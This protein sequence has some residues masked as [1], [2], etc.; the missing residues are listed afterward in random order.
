METFEDG[1]EV[2]ARLV[3]DGGVGMVDVTREGVLLPFFNVR[4]GQRWLGTI[5]CAVF[6]IA[7]GGLHGNYSLFKEAVVSYDETLEG[8]FEAAH[9]WRLG[10]MNV[11]IVMAALVLLRFPE[12]TRVLGMVGFVL[13]GAHSFVAFGIQSSL[14]WLFIF[15]SM[16]LGVSIG[17]LYAVGVKLLLSWIPESQWLPASIAVGSYAAGFWLGHYLLKAVLHYLHVIPCMYTLA[18]VLTMIGI[19]TSEDCR[20]PFSEQNYDAFTGK[21]SSPSSD[22]E[23]E[24]YR[25]QDTSNSNWEFPVSTSSGY[26][27]RP[28]QHQAFY[29]PRHN[30]S[31]PAVDTTATKYS[32]T[33]HNYVTQP[34]VSSLPPNTNTSMSRSYY[35]YE[36]SRQSMPAKT[37]F[38]SSS[39]LPY[40]QIQPPPDGFYQEPF[41]YNN[42]VRGRTGQAPDEQI[43]WPSTANEG[44][45]PPRQPIPPHERIQQ[46]YR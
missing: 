27:P 29:H 39:S 9:S 7:S 45:R 28:T 37:N 23:S 3:V 43:R 15:G 30:T 1:R 13:A 6:C 11:A 40:A 21:I 42:G 44:Q 14:P 34:R 17:L 20:L 10:S 31:V 5:P 22:V 26:K 12:R 2:G 33:T 35:N 16:L 46:Q 32:H 38:H 41:Y 4:V 24:E 36:N 19:I 25:G 18:L 8:A